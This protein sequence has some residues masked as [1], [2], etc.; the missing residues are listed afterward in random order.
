MATHDRRPPP[1]PEQ[2]NWW[3]E[4][5]PAPDASRGYRPE[6]LQQFLQRTTATLGLLVAELHRCDPPVPT[7]VLQGV[8]QAWRALGELG[9]RPQIDRPADI[10]RHASTALRLIDHPDRDNWDPRCWEHCDRGEQL[11]GE[12]LARLDR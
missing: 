3:D 10:L 5:T 11:L 9:D 1:L 2:P 4:P 6:S 8:E 7:T 12:L